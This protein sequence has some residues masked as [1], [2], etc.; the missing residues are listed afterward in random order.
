MA[1]TPSPLLDIR[2]VRLLKLISLRFDSFQGQGSLDS[3]TLRLQMETFPLDADDIKCT[4]SRVPGYAALS[5]TW[6][7]AMTPDD[8]II[9]PE[10]RDSDTTKVQMG[11]TTSSVDGVYIS[12]V[13]YYVTKSLRDAL[14]R[15]WLSGFRRRW[16]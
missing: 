9:N 7:P 3:S 4:D 15:L 14:L 13:P 8:S 5:Y 1:N 12:W 6:G 16:L 2:S 10:A 11:I